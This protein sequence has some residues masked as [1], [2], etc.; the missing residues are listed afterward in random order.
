M[1]WEATLKEDHGVETPINLTNHAYW[2][3]SGDFA[4]PTVSEHTLMLKAARIL[5]CDD[6]WCPNGTISDVAG[7]VFDF[8]NT[9]RVGDKERL[10]GGIDAGGKPGIDHAF[11]VDGFDHEGQNKMREVAVLASPYSGIKM[12][13]E[14][15]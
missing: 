5:D 6:S 8:R 14:S 11:C 9:E 4:E 12:K 3:L 2:N 13:V 1:T 15:T 7:T 10:T